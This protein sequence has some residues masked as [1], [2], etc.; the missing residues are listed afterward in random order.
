MK[1]VVPAGPLFRDAVFGDGAAWLEFDNG[2]GMKSSD[3]RPLRTFEIAGE[4]GLFVEA[5]ASV[6]NGKI[7]V[8]SPA[9]KSPRYVRYGWQPYTT[10]NLVNGAGLP[11]STFKTEDETL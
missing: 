7:K 5:V 9:V 8:S 1:N 4:D 11:A 6:E 10:A 2:E 3:G